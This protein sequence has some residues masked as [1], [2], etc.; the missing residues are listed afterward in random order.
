MYCI[1]I[2]QHSNLTKYLAVSSIFMLSKLF[3]QSAGKM[4][5]RLGVVALIAIVMRPHISTTHVRKAWGMEAWPRIQ[6]FDIYLM[7]GKEKQMC[8]Y[9]LK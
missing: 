2:L 1:K 4:K 5:G 9:L 6:S 7:G 3:G 8:S